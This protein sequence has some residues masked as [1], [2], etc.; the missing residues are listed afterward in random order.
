M[1]RAFLYDGHL[2]GIRML[3]G[4]AKMLLF[5]SDAG[6]KTIEVNAENTPL[7]K[8]ALR[9]NAPSNIIRKTH[10]YNIWT[11]SRTAFLFRGNFPKVTVRGVI[12]ILPNGEEKT[13]SPIL[14]RHLSQSGRP[15]ASSLKLEECYI[16]ILRIGE[17]SVRFI[18]F[19]ALSVLS[20]S[21][22]I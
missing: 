10:S 6:R 8:N 16:D 22:S 13:D 20:Q 18:L 5:E 4:G 15:L 3:W 17:E 14:I 19:V 9:Y 7:Y 12:A 1:E 2:G 11:H 21:I